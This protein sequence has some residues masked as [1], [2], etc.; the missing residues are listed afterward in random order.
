MYQLTVVSHPQQLLILFI[1][2]V[3]HFSTEVYTS[4]LGCCSGR[5]SEEE[6]KFKIQ[7]PT[8]RLRFTCGQLQLLKS[9]SHTT[10]RRGRLREAISTAP[11][12]SGSGRVD[13]LTRPVAAAR[14]AVATGA[15]GE[16]ETHVYDTWKCGSLRFVFTHPPEDFFFFYKREGFMHKYYQD[17][18]AS[19]L[20]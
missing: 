4:T 11:D 19:N 15:S 1:L 10:R 7:P 2:A 16:I 5:N 20:N 8:E 12:L 17:T 3:L 6:A 13:M 18:P 14:A 9:N